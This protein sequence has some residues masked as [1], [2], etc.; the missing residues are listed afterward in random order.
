MDWRSAVRA[1]VLGVPILYGGLFVLGIF[2]AIFI[3]QLNVL[4]GTARG[5]GI[6]V[7]LASMLL[8]PFGICFAVGVIALALAARRRKAGVAHPRQDSAP[9]A[10]H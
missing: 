5:A 3:P 7:V 4:E 6:A 10:G 8:I 2:H 9:I 1:G